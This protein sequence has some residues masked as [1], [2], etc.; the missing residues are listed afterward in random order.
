MPSINGGESMEE[1]LLNGEKVLLPS[2]LVCRVNSIVYHFGSFSKLEVSS[3]VM[4][5]CPWTLIG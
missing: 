1:C 2:S 5:M 3:S 4:S